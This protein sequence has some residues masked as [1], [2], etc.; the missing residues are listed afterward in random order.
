MMKKTLQLAYRKSL[1]VMAGY[2]VLGIGFGILLK[3]AGYGLFWSFLMSL[4]IYAGSMQYV[5]VSLLTAG[6]SLITVALTA[7]MVNARH[8]FY[9]LSM[10]GKYK[11][12]GRKKPYLIFS[13]TDE[14]YSLLCSDEIPEGA[15]RHG[16]QFW[17]SLFNQCYWILGSVL[18][19]LVG[20]LFPFDTAGIDFSMT[21]LFVTVFVEQWLTTKNHL[22]AIIGLAASVLCL[23]IFGADNFLLPTM[24]TITVALLLTKKSNSAGGEAHV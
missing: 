9:G 8:L 20:T 22:P 5:S 2:I 19:S 3:D 17:V 11:D 7:L 18:G 24:I 16:Y 13:L 14:T 4:T 12:G 23:V 10:I 21:A 1:P 6:A 15:D